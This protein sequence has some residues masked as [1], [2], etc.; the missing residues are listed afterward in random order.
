MK[1]MYFI[2]SGI[3]FS[4][5]GFLAAAP[6]QPPAPQ[7]TWRSPVKTAASQAETF[8][9]V[10]SGDS[11]SCGNKNVTWTAD[12]QIRIGNGKGILLSIYPYFCYETAEKKVDWDP[13]TKSECRVKAENGKVT[14]ILKKKLGDQ[15]YDSCT[16]TLEITPEGL[17]KVQSRFE[18]ISAPGWQPWSPNASFFFFLPYEQSEGKNLIL[19]GKCFRLDRKTKVICDTGREKQYKYILYP[20]D[21]ADT[22]SLSAVRPD[23]GF[24]RCYPDHFNKAFRI[25]IVMNKEKSCT[26][27]L[28]LRKGV[29]EASSPDKRGGIDFQAIEK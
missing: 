7:K 15:V 5:A 3:F 20:D 1:K 21:A 28:D 2:L 8:K 24:S 18:L 27:T 16:Q 19:N 29:Q 26:F 11:I 10:F 6:V 17:L 25:I 14:W 4:A 13:F 12:G 22:I 9:P 23:A